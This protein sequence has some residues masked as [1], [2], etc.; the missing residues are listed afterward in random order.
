MEL[1]VTNVIHNYIVN[2]QI[3][4]QAIPITNAKLREQLC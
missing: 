3:S 1:L 2:D 4:F